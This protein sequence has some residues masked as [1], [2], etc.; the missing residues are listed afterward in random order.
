M[1]CSTSTHPV[2]VLFQQS[3]DQIRPLDVQIHPSPQHRRCLLDKIFPE[4]GNLLKTPRGKPVH[5]DLLHE[6]CR[7]SCPQS[8]FEECYAVVNLALLETAKR[9]T[10]RQV[11]DDIK[12][13]EVEPMP[14][15]ENRLGGLCRA[16]FARSRVGKAACLQLLHHQI[17]VALDDGLLLAQAFLAEAMAELS[18][19]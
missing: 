2:L 10:E 5:A 16:L 6:V 12:S 17:D 18:S 14:H 4:A 13:D 19:D 9:F 7:A 11:T 1:F 3:F 8:L 15:V